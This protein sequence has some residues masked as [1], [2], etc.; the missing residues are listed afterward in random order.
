MQSWIA[1]QNI[2]RYEALLAQ[3]SDPAQ[4][5][6][7]TDLLQQEKRKLHDEDAREEAETKRT[8]S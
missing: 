8:P 7:I 3:E 5:T 2:A 1:R 6:L 4:R